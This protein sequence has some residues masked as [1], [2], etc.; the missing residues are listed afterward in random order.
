KIFS[1]N[2]HI[3][4]PIPDIVH[5]T[6]G[7]AR[8]YALTHMIFDQK[9]AARDPYSLSQ[10]Q[11]RILGVVQYVHKHDTIETGGLSWNVHS[12]KQ[13]HWDPNFWPDRHIDSF[14][15]H[16]RAELHD[17]CGE[18]TISRPHIK[19]PAVARQTSSQMLRQHSDSSPGNERTMHRIKRTLGARHF[20]SDFRPQ[21]PADCD[22]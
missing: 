9:S 11:C 12:I 13:S 22:L 17:S 20:D 2:G 4:S 7:R 16:V 19:D 1:S 15:C 6:Q 8:Q 14:N 10:Q 5:E 18:R 21:R 3:M